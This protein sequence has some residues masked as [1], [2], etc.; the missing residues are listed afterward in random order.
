MP[1]I[2]FVREKKEIEVPEGSNLREVAL[3]N[4]IEVYPGINRVLNCL[5]HGSCGSCRV[6]MLKGSVKNTGPRTWP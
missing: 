5:G 3:A 6:L 2:T 4:G 1:K